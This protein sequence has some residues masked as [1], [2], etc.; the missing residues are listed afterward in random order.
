M[1]DTEALKI[2]ESC[3]DEM[4][5]NSTPPTTWAEIK[6]KYGGTRNTFYDKHAIT[7]ARYNNIRDSYSKKL[8]SYYKRKL[9]WFL[10][11]YAPTFEKENKEIKDE[12]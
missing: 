1:N 11:D 8:N 7:E 5:R 4:Y 6:K 9:S 10:L 3:I 12:S 2:F